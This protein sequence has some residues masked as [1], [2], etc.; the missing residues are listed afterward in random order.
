MGQ[1]QNIGQ[2]FIRNNHGVQ[3]CWIE[4][5]CG[6]QWSQGI[7]TSENKNT[8]RFNRVRDK[9]LGAYKNIFSNYFGKILRKSCCNLK[10]EKWE[11]HI[12]LKY[13]KAI[14]QLFLVPRRGPHVQS[15]FSQLSTQIEKEPNLHVLRAHSWH[16]KYLSSQ[17]SI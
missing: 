14:I 13:V 7:L 16:S 9:D 17:C 4:K 6:V 8:V 2:Y 5:Y 15:M 10:I 3:W 12:L 11:F 1:Y